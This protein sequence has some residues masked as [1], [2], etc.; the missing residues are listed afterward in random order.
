MEPC[1]FRHGKAGLA[2]PRR[3][4]LRASMEPCLF[5]HGKDATA[6]SRIEAF[7][8]LQW[9]HVFSDMVSMQ[10]K[11]LTGL[12]APLQWSH[13]FSDMVRAEQDLL[14]QSAEHASMEPCLFRHGKGGIHESLRVRPFSFNGAMSFQTW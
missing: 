14:P 6:V 13:V 2:D 4:G 12:P 10:G 9:S 5:R 3:T 8:K 11:A 7:Y 1:L